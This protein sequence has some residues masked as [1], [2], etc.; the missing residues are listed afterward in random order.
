MVF[1]F[2]AHRRNQDGQVR[3]DREQIH[4][5]RAW[6]AIPAPLGN[7]LGRNVTKPRHFSGSAHSV[8]QKIS[9]HVAHRRYGNFSYRQNA[10]HSYARSCNARRMERINERI[11]RFREQ[12]GMSQGALARAVGVSRPAV[13]KWENGDTE[14]LKL[15]NLIRLCQIFTI[16]ADKLIGAD[17][18]GQSKVVTTCEPLAEYRVDAATKMPESILTAYDGLTEDGRRLVK[19]Q[20]EVAIETARKLYGSQGDK[21]QNAA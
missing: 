17:A 8:D 7:S 11:K 9:F 14:N 5:A 19:A 1:C 3:A 12:A 21:E 20:I 2:F 15:G 10:N 18:Y 13:S 6:Y 16:S 4:A